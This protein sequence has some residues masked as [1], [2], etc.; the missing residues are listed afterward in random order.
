MTISGAEFATHEESEQHLGDLL[1]RLQ[2]FGEV[3]AKL[4]GG[5]RNMLGARLLENVERLSSPTRH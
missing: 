3:E 4:S 2:S 1:A 5:L